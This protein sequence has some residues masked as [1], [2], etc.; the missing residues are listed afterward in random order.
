MHC[1]SRILA[2]AY[3]TRSASSAP[4]AVGRVH[5]PE[6]DMRSVLPHRA[7]LLK[8]L[9]PPRTT[10]VDNP[11]R[12]RGTLGNL[13]DTAT[14]Q[15][16]SGDLLGLHQTAH[17]A[18]QDG[19]AVALRAVTL[20]AVHAAPDQHA[21]DATLATLSEAG[22]MDLM[23]ISTIGAV[24]DVLVRRALRSDDYALAIRGE[25]LS[26]VLEA[27]LRPCTYVEL[28]SHAPDVPVALSAAHRAVAIG[29]SDDTTRLLRAVLQVATRT[30]NEVY[31]TRAATEL[32]QR[33]ELD[34]ET[35]AVILRHAKTTAEVESIADVM[36]MKNAVEVARALTRVKDVTST[37]MVAAVERALMIGLAGAKEVADKA[38]IRLVTEGKV[39]A[40]LRVWREMR[41]A[42]GGRPGERARVALVAGLGRRNER[43][44][45]ELMM[46]LRRGAGTREIRRMRRMRLRMGEDGG[47]D[48][49]TLG[50]GN[51]KDQATV[52]HRWAR[53]GRGEEVEK[54]VLD[55]VQRA[56][57]KGIDDRVVRALLSDVRDGERGVRRWM[58]IVQSG[59]GVCGK[60]EDV[61]RRASEGLWRWIKQ[62][63]GA[64]AGRKDMA[65]VGG[66]KMVSKDEVRRWVNAVVRVAG[67]GI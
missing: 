55:Q 3:A 7:L 16:N 19:R 6:A 37:K 33:T 17:L 66:D 40:G 63:G 13:C 24:L 18:I 60:R 10:R 44:D 23:D 59:S 5:A 39:E 25:R 43:G 53:T 45:S 65:D 57:G 27:P 52:L 41:R 12:I 67:E 49:A 1:T 2:R 56:E 47:M 35:I 34:C 28:V 30:N 22:M 26:R 20:S 54:W 14:Q 48:R 58:Q 64:A 51:V 36:A 31:A 61:V 8:S 32:A 38:V 9:R 4:R 50:C 15:A 29:M 11:G 21:R 62:G 42:W 46:R